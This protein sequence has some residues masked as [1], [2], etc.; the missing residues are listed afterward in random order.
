MVSNKYS[1]PFTFNKLDPH[2]SGGCRPRERHGVEQGRA[3]AGADSGGQSAWPGER[4]AADK[5]SINFF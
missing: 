1:E 2:L 5:K 3:E 4:T